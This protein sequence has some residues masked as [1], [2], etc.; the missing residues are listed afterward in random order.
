MT[1]REI[2]L[3]ILARFSYCGTVEGTLSN[4][5]TYVEG[6]IGHGFLSFEFNSDG[7]VVE[8]DCGG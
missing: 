4:G 1:E 8:V 5:N 6:Y 7:K 2:I 3:E